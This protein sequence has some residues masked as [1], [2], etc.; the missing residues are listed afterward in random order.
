MTWN[1]IK[2]DDYGCPNCSISNGEKKVEE[3]LLK[4]EI[5]YNREHKFE[6]CTYVKELPFD[7]YLPCYNLCIEYQ[8]IQHYEPIDFLGKGRES[9]IK[10]FDL[11]KI[12][13]KIK[14]DYCQKNKIFLLPIHY[15][16]FDNIEFIIKNKIGEFDESAN[17]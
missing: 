10:S 3:C 5:D 8:G 4:M 6:N 7:F 9:A 17:V 2:R 14:E 12:K 15:N 16:D 11:I 1:N 13:D